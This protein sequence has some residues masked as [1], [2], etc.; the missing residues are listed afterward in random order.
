[1]KRRQIAVDGVGDEGFVGEI[2]RLGPVDETGDRVV[3]GLDLGVE[4]HGRDEDDGEEP[5]GQHDAASQLVGSKGAHLVRVFH[6]QVAVHWQH[7]QYEHAGTLTQINEGKVD[8]AKER[9]EEPFALPHCDQQNGDEK[10]IEKIANG[11][12]EQIEIGDC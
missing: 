7:D 2:P 9:A 11:Q 1:M 12:V 6:R 3:F 4:K 5:G 8:F 10:R